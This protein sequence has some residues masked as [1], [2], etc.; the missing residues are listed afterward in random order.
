MVRMHTGPAEPPAVTTAVPTLPF[1]LDFS[2][3]LVALP[4][5]AAA[6][7]CFLA[8]VPVAIMGFATFSVALNAASS[9]AI[10][11]LWYVPDSS[12]S[13][14]ALGTAC[15]DEEEAAAIVRE[16]A[17]PSFEIFVCWAPCCFRA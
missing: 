2:T 13:L 9:L 7:V 5:L 1:L 14:L 6:G 17:R 3:G 16:L 15:M 12:G 11:F 8:F 10:G 4:R